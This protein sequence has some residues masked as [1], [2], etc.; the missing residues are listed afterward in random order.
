MYLY[1]RYMSRSKSSSKSSYKSGMSELKI[2]DN[3]Q[4][5]I[6]FTALRNGQGGFDFLYDIVNKKT[7]NRTKA[8]KLDTNYGKEI[9]RRNFKI[10]NEYKLKYNIHGGRKTRNKRNQLKSKKS[11]YT[12]TNKG[13]LSK[14]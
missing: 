3:V 10:K 1:Y 2:Y 4:N 12:K 6:G 8:S 14:K 13:K 5:P 9:E 11:S 7:Y